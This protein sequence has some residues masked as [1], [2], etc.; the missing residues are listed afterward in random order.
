M[1]NVAD[2]ILDLSSLLDYNHSDDIV[3]FGNDIL[4]NLKN[5]ENL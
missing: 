5:L 4:S 1:I 2:Y 3:L